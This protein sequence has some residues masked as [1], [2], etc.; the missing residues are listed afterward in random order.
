LKLEAIHRFHSQ[1]R[2][3]WKETVNGANTML[4]SQPHRAMLDISPVQ[5][6]VLRDMLVGMCD[7]TLT[8]PKVDKQVIEYILNGRSIFVRESSDP[9]INPSTAAAEDRRVSRAAS[10]PHDE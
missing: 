1:I 6:K 2:V 9:L 4:D 8:R 3:K 7:R 5:I 10:Y